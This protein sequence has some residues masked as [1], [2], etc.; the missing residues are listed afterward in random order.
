MYSSKTVTHRAKSHLRVEI[1]NF[2][3]MQKN[4]ILRVD[5]EIGSGVWG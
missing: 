4:P 2:V 1:S 3:F 5:V